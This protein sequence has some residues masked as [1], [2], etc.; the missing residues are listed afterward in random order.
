MSLLP[1]I[2]TIRESEWEYYETELLTT[3]SLGISTRRGTWLY[4]VVINGDYI[5]RNTYNNDVLVSSV[6]K[7]LGNSMNIE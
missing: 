2:R 4:E 3:G 1:L 6:S 5:V 7:I